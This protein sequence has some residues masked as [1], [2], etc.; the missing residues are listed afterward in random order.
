MTA[1]VFIGRTQVD[2]LPAEN[3]GLAYGDGLFET[4][5]VHRGDI[6]W[7]NAHWSRLRRGAARLRIRLPDE[8]LVRDQ[9]SQLFCNEDG[10]LKLI[11]TR[12]TDGRGYAPVSDTEPTWL[13]S[14][15]SL[16]AEPRADGLI[17]R[18]CDTRLAIQPALAGLK[19]CNRL[20]Q[21]IARGEW[22]DESI[23]ESL[24]RDSEGFVVSA[25]SANLFVLRDG[26][27]VTPLIDRCGVAGVCRAWCMQEL[28]A[29]EARLTV[30]DVESADAVFLCNAV[31][32]ILSVARLDGREW[33]LHSQVAALQAR[34]AQEH[35]AFASDR[36]G[37]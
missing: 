7:W 9:T 29:H 33:S 15:H 22:Q 6:R 11:I 21:V 17:V 16:P 30:E 37:S 12:G 20:E 26:A 25:V 34:L 1:L 5:R 14:R 4:M 36:E 23:D 35:P 3:R 2:S 10:V 32:G 13:L 31:R 8:S 18:W 27:W 28:A 19:H 24:M